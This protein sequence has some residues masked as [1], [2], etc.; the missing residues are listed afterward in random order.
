MGGAAGLAI[1]YA[2]WPRER[3]IP[4][5]VRDDETAINAFLKF[6]PDGSITVAVPQAEM[7]QGV[8]TALPQLLAHELG[9]DWQR[10]G[11]EPATLAPEYANRAFVENVGEGMPSLLGGIARWAA[12]TVVERFELQATG[13]STS[14]MAFWQPLRVAG[15]AAREMLLRA[16]G[17]RLGVSPDSLDTDN[18]FVAA[19][20]GT[21][22]AFADLLDAVDPND[23]PEEPRLRDGPGLLGKAVP[24]L[25]IPSK[26]NGSAQFGA[27]VRL[28][29]MVYAAVRGAPIGAGA[30]RR[31]GPAAARE[32][33]GVLDIV[34]GEG[35]YAVVAETWWQARQ[36]L[37]AVDI[38]YDSGSLANSEEIDAALADALEDPDAGTAFT[39]RGDVETAVGGG[40]SADYGAPFLAHACLEPM[41][42]TVRID[43]D[44]AEVWAP[45]QSQTLT[46][47]KAADALDMPMRRVR[48]YPTML[49]GGFGRKAEVDAVVQAASIAREVG[50]PVQLI[51]HREQDMVHDKFRPPVRAR[52]RGA[53]GPDKRLKAMDIKLAAP[54]LGA[55]MA[56]RMAPGILSGMAGAGGD[57]ASMVAGLSELPYDIPALRVRHA[58]VETPVELGYWRSVEYSYAPFLTES[59]IDE[60]AA[61]A[62]VDPLEFRLRHLDADSRA[63]KVI[64][65]AAAQG[66]LLGAADEGVGR[67]LAY[68]RSFGTHVAQVAEVEMIGGGQFEVRRVTCVVDCGQVVNPD[69][70]KAQMEGG[71]IFGLS[72]ALYG[73]ISFAAGETE[74]QNFDLY[75]L[76]SLYDAPEID[77]HIVDS[78]EAPGG[79]GEPGVPPIAPAVANAVF[80]ASGT[81]LRSMPFMGF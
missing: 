50:R 19:K 24:R 10:I 65:L 3:S 67:G 21:R 73:D 72:A 68:C 30:R 46:A 55:S 79:V 1:G 48:V 60:L 38:E 17:R 12:V 28:P 66:T 27:D 61:Q 7:G 29:G 51:W 14:V 15:A 58:D 22:I 31:F 70:V 6:A 25:D 76:V 41:T 34:P 81:R 8:Y 64:M 11:V 59:F 45:T 75:R 62:G 54:N 53:V 56:A 2:V 16:A 52:L 5:P 49:G 26:V 36:A 35:W 44:R 77:V 42:A 78:E 9:A 43:G 39:D 33:P 23:L 47:W 18:G 80:R 69:I 63:A 57:S 32:M 20:D 4:I 71:I 13:G 37:D 40:L 74:Q